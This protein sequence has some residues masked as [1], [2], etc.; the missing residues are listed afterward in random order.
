M[1][2]KCIVRE[3][4]NIALC[5]ANIPY[6]LCVQ[7]FKFSNGNIVCKLAG[8]LLLPYGF[9]VYVRDEVRTRSP[10]PNGIPMRMT[11]VNSLSAQYGGTA[12]KYRNILNILENALPPLFATPNVLSS[13]CISPYTSFSFQQCVHRV[14]HMWHMVHYIIAFVTSSSIWQLAFMRENA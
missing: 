6:V 5:T 1:L 9:F 2:L 13:A 4:R 11:Y 3:L 10:R 8:T 7:I 12:I 14:W